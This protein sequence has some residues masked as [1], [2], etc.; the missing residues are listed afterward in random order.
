[1][2]VSFGKIDAYHALISSMMSKS[3][4]LESIQAENGPNLLPLISIL[5]GFVFI[6]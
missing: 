2:F 4:T 6:H 5:P 1:M 3:F